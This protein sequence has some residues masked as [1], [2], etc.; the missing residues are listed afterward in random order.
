MRA[1][2]PEPIHRHTSGHKD[3]TTRT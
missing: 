3:R 2:S 1:D